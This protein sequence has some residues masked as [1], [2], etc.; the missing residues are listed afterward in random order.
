M[1]RQVCTDVSTGVLMG[2][3]VAEHARH[4]SLQALGL[5]LEERGPTWY[6]ATSATQAALERVVRGHEQGEV[7]VVTW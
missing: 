6:S 2:F 7:A 5:T 3:V 1:G 4:R